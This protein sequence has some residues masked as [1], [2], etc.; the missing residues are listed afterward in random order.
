M[1][2]LMRSQLETYPN[3]LWRLIAG[4]VL[5]F[6][7][8]QGLLLRRQCAV[9]CWRL[10]TIQEYELIPSVTSCKRA[11]AQLFLSAG[12]NPVSAAHPQHPIPPA[13]SCQASS[14][15]QPIIRPLDANHP[16]L[17]SPLSSRSSGPHQP[18]IKPLS[19]DQQTATSHQTAANHPDH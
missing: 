14:P 7:C 16:A 17:S 10:V 3:Q 13:F 5:A 2:Q 11:R 8:Y 15:Q 9:A 1:A 6:G 4:A 12:K 19:A 18:I